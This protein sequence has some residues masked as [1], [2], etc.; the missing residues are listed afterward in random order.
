VRTDRPGREIE[1]G[2]DLLV[3]QAGHSEFSNFPF[4][5]RQGLL[6]PASGAYPPGASCLQLGIGALRPRAGAEALEGFT[7]RR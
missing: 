7:G 4:L 3:T 1:P 5:G 2:G 6:A